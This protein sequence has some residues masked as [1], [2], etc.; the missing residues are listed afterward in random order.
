MYMYIIVIHN[1]IYIYIYIYIIMMDNIFI[2]QILYVYDIIWYIIHSYD[3][4]L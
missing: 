4:N 3:N 1:T 2:I